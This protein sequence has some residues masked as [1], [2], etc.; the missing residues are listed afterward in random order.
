MT[1]LVTRYR[2][3]DCSAA[4]FGD[5]IIIYQDADHDGDKEFVNM[6]AVDEQIRFSDA[7]ARFDQ[8]TGQ[9]VLW[10]TGGPAPAPTPTPTP[11]PPAACPDLTA[12]LAAIRNALP[13]AVSA[14]DSID[15]QL[16]QLRAFIGT[17]RN[18]VGSIDTKL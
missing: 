2:M 14:L 8:P 7:I 13:M 11:T 15:A 6:G 1:V 10:S 12:E 5:T 9:L 17:I 3:A 16:R 18:A 4:R